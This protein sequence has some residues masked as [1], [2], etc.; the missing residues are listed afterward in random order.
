MPTFSKPICICGSDKAT[1]YPNGMLNRVELKCDSC[2]Q[3]LEIQI[4]DPK[5]TGRTIRR[6][7]SYAIS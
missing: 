7:T 1:Y 3:L 2:K 5:S 4:P 6:G